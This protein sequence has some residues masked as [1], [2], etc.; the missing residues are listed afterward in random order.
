MFCDCQSSVMTD[1][2]CDKLAVMD[3]H[4]HKCAFCETQQLVYYIPNTGPFSSPLLSLSIGWMEK[5]NS[6][7]WPGLCFEEGTWSRISWGVCL[8][9][10]CVSVSVC[11]FFCLH[12]VTALFKWRKP[13]SVDCRP[14]ATFGNHL[15]IFCQ[16]ELWNMKWDPGLCSIVSS[17]PIFLCFH[18]VHLAYVCVHSNRHLRQSIQLWT[19]CLP[20]FW[21]VLG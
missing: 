19:K 4:A 13:W 10:V 8:L 16:W 17:L 21:E 20:A 12:G 18:W 9:F 15:F 1:F 11:V 5:K 3:R 14:G 7:M 2:C 6:H